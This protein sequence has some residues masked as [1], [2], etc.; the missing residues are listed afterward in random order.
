MYIEDNFEE[1]EKVRT[2]NSLLVWIKLEN[3]QSNFSVVQQNFLNF[4]ADV[5]KEATKKW[6]NLKKRK[7]NSEQER[8]K[9]LTNSV[10]E[11]RSKSLQ[12][13]TAT[14]F[15]DLWYLRA[16]TEL[17]LAIFHFG[18][19]SEFVN[20]D[21]KWEE[22]IL[23]Q[24]KPLVLRLKSPSKSNIKNYSLNKE[25]KRMLDPIAKNFEETAGIVAKFKIPKSYINFEKEL[26]KKHE[27][28]KISVQEFENF[29]ATYDTE[30]MRK[31]LKSVYKILFQ[32]RE[33]L[34]RLTQACS[35]R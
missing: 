13:L 15:D 25:I 4:V 16:E 24:S 14:I 30:K 2:I 6:W 5:A 7:F 26:I 1:F 9:E 32:L 33:E 29:K 10:K 23:E 34:T 12:Q 18:F 28:A 35:P 3:I 19:I 17:L 27:S 22:K 11:F 21:F 8:I 31:K 20:R